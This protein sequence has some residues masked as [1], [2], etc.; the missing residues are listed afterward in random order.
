M[1]P[2]R[3]DRGFDRKELR[4]VGVGIEFCVVVLAFCFAGYLIDMW[5]E[6][7]EPEF[8]ITG[9]FIG[10]VFMMYWLFKST[11]ELRK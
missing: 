10:F 9:F 8:M 3:D 1:R 2:V 11:R 6:N 4:W 7:E 5:I